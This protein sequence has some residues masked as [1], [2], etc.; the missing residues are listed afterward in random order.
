MDDDDDFNDVDEIVQHDDIIDEP[1]LISVIHEDD[2]E[3]D[4]IDV[5][6]AHLELVDE[7]EFQV[8][9]NE[10]K[11][12]THDDELVETVLQDDLLDDVDEVE[13]E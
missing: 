5:H 9:Q 1:H 2:D 13:L 8:A 3:H 10:K 11:N 6:E 7:Y 4:E 12:G